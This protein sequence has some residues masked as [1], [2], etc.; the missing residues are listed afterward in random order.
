MY[1]KLIICRNPSTRIIS[2]ISVVYYTYVRESM[3]NF[4]FCISFDS[5][6]FCLKNNYFLTS[7]DPSKD[8]NTIFLIGI[9]QSWVFKFSFFVISFY[10]TRQ[11]TSIQSSNSALAFSLKVNHLGGGQ[12]GGSA[13]NLCIII[14]PGF[15]FNT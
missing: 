9:L 3:G 13:G 10:Q 4:Y 5:N 6:R 11:P 2:A 1:W 14:L 7:K 8:V 15:S 12:T